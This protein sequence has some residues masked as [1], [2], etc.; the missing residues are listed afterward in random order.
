[1]VAGVCLALVALLSAGAVSL[2]AVGVHLPD[3]LELASLLMA[4]A[5]FWGMVGA[6]RQGS[7]IRVDFLS[8]LLPP[9][10]TA[11]M[12][13]LA[14]A[15]TSAALLLTA[16]AGIGQA[17]LTYRSGEVT[18]ELRL[19]LWPL[20]ALGLGGVALSAIVSAALIVPRARLRPSARPENT[21]VAHGE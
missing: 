20:L 8:S 7:L 15:A 4:V 14:Q 12:R 19:P 1:M 16:R 13:L 18:P 5:V 2:R 6:V 10:L 21:G 17:L 9:R 3:A 11:L